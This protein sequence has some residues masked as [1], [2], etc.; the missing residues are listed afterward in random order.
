MAHFFKREVDPRANDE[1][2]KYMRS[3]LEREKKIDKE[4]IKRVIKEQREKMRQRSSSSNRQ[5]S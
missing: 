3:A 4:Y 5:N 2:K 1:G